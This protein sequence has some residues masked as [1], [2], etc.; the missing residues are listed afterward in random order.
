M[1]LDIVTLLTT[2]TEVSDAG[3]P[4]DTVIASRDVFCRVVSANDR[5]KTLAAS[6]GETA[7]L[8]AILADKLDYDEQIFLTYNGKKYRIIDTRFSDTSTE[9]RLTLEK[10][11]TQ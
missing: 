5:E 10:W 7:E 4:I 9:L 11:Q 8:V 3:D 6:R 1:F 2:Q